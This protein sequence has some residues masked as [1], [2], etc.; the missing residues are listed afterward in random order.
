M[1]INIP[2]LPIHIDVQ[3]RP[4]R[5]FRL[6]V[7]GLMVVVLA[8]GLF[9]SLTVR[10][11][12]LRNAGSYHAQQ[13]VLVTVQRSTSPPTVTAS[14]INWHL[15]RSQQNHD[16]ASRLESILGPSLLSV[17]FLAILAIFGRVLHSRYRRSTAAN[18]DRLR[19]EGAG[20]DNPTVD[21][22]PSPA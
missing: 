19:L 22:T 21:P 2:L 4:L 12:Q 8:A 7:L 5:P 18:Q 20:R 14:L 16:A 13:T 1:R 17:L 10:I 11:T 15:S 6:T 9:L 3:W